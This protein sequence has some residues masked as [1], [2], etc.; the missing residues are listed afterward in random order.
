DAAWAVRGPGE[1]DAA[2]A[3][4]PRIGERGARWPAWSRQEQSGV[5]SDPGAL[6]ALRDANVAYE[7]QFGHV[8]LICATGRGPDEILAE[9]RRRMA[10]DRST[11]REVAAAE[12]G[13]IN[14]IRLRKLVTPSEPEGRGVAWTEE[15]GARNERRA[16]REGG[17]PKRP[18]GERETL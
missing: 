15:R 2:M 11:E 16:T 8:F 14:A 18:A 5:G 6:E 12:I 9:L 13:K 7:G 3:G 1:L 17:A 10:N 4:H